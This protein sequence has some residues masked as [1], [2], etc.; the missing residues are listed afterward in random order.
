MNC[1]FTIE[2]EIST[3]K[4]TNILSF[5]AKEMQKQAEV[6]FLY[7]NGKTFFKVLM[8]SVGEGLGKQIISYILRV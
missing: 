4:Y 1:Q 3:I 2:V 7:Q 8:S 6:L 5:T